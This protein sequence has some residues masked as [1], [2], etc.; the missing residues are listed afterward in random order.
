MGW[1]DHLCR[2]EPGKLRVDSRKAALTSKVPHRVGHCKFGNCKFCSSIYDIFSVYTHEYLKHPQVLESLPLQLQM[3]RVK[4]VPMQSLSP[5]VG[6]QAA[7][8]PRR[9]YFSLSK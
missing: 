7:S 3:K 8:G 9:F 4:V 5:T 6:D 2:C 1:S